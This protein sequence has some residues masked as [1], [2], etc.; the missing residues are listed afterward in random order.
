VSGHV[1]F[2]RCGD[3]IKIGHTAH[4]AIRLSLFRRWA[5]ELLAAFPGSLEDARQLYQEFAAYRIG[6]Q[7]EA[8]PG[9]PQFF[10]LPD[11]VIEDIVAKYGKA[12]D[13]MIRDPTWLT[14]MAGLLGSK[15]RTDR[16]LEAAGKRARYTVKSAF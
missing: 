6:K 10:A 2:A 1:Y 3:L 13:R 15:R 16:K 8:D 12:Q 9:R 11:Y 5:I 4:L 14:A 7:I